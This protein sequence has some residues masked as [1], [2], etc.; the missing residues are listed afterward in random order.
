MTKKDF[1]NFL[2]IL[3]IIS[4]SIIM[5]QCLFWRVFLDSALFQCVFK[6]AKKLKKFFSTAVKK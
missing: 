3:L 1:I 5:V 6:K 4:P 2:V